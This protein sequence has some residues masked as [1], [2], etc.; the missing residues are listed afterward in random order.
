MGA[1]LLAILLKQMQ[2]QEHSRKEFIVQ[3]AIGFSLPVFA[4]I[5]CGS[6]H[7]TLRTR[8]ERV[9]QTYMN[10]DNSFSGGTIMSLI[11]WSDSPLSSI[12][13]SIFL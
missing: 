7:D 3:L 5:L 9:L 6:T 2:L 1:C 10:L 12:A 11:T 13:A 8:H 4:I